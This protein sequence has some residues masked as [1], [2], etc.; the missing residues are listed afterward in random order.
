MPD[1][2]GRARITASVEVNLIQKV[3]SARERPVRRVVKC[4]YCMDM[5]SLRT[6]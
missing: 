2:S 3:N 4:Y 6:E 1:F 5:T